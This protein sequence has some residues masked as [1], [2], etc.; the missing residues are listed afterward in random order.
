[1]RRLF[2]PLLS[3]LALAPGARA[4][5]D[6]PPSFGESIDVRVV[7]VEAVVTD[8]QGNRVSG[9]K[10]EDFR[11]R[12]DGREVPVEYFNEVRDG[13]ALP[14]APEAAAPAEQPS[15]PAKAAVQGVAEGRIGTYYLLFIDDFFSI[16]AQRNA[17]L[18]GL[19]DDLGRLGPA[20]RMAIVA[21]G[22]GRLTM[23]SNWSGSPADLGRAF[24][25]AMARRTRSLGRQAE[26]A[27][28]DNE[29]D[30]SK[31]SVA[32]GAPL[33]LASQQPGLSDIQRRYASDLIRQ[34]QGDVQAAV[35]ALRA[36]A[37]PRGRKVMLLLSGGWPFSVQSYASRGA[38]MPTKELP[39]GEELYKPLTSTANLLGYTLYPVD[40]PGVQSGAADVN[41]T[42]PPTSAGGGGEGGGG[43]LAPGQLLGGFGNLSEHEIEGSL[44][45]IAQE[46]GG[47]PILNSNRGLAL[48]LARE[49]TR[50]FY[51]LGFSPS[52]K[53][54]DKGHRI[55]LETRRRDLQVRTRSG[56]L[57]LSRKAE[58]S[59]LVE[60]AL[61]FGN[62]PGALRM[63]LK[64]GQVTRS[65]RGEIEIPITLGLPVDLMTVVPEG[66]KYTAR[67]EL[68]FAASDASGDTAEIPTIPV[69]LTSDHPP[70]PGKVVKYETKVKLR[71]KADHMVVAAYDP[72]SGKIA[73]AE[74]D[75]KVP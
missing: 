54:D 58:V 5:E 50:S 42:P 74:T 65:K 67:L 47:K 18:K 66:A 13:E 22:G 48:G 24:D 14:A 17:V 25:Q 35:S 31:Q 63:P 32:D 55:Q 23:L 4:A 71:G 19:K 62:P 29:Q 2:V 7:N 41:A 9:L 8:R 69:T 39:E 34:L 52:W 73:T 70:S 59:M 36:F 43:L 11:L 15:A 10:P 40:V 38:G 45:Y 51:W 16:P 28:A 12:V 27:S 68:R 3:L 57:D 60:S 61:L 64:V 56:F 46:T 53:R 21:Y 30:F 49:D 6:T 75:V 26:R 44:K 20:D 33:D 37:A 1:M 72:L